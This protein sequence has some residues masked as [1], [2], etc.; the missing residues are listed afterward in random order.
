[1]PPMNAANKT[2]NTIISHSKPP[3]NVIKSA[4]QA[5]TPEMIAELTQPMS[6]RR[7]ELVDIKNDTAPIRTEI[8]NV[9]IHRDPG[10]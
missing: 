4:K 10:I 7:G 8:I 2:N 6:R 5:A 9:P 1:M 3:S